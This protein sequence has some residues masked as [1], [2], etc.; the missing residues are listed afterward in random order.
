MCAVPDRN[1]V[2]TGYTHNTDST[3]AQQQLPYQGLLLSL[4]GHEKIHRDE[5]VLFLQTI[6][7]LHLRLGG[8]GYSDNLHNDP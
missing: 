7:A 1:S 3:G 5:N 4:F 2:V 6:E 8:T